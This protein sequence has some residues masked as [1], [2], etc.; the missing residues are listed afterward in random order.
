VPEAITWI[1]I[2]FIKSV[3]HFDPCII[4]P[5]QTLH[6]FPEWWIVPPYRIY[7]TWSTEKKLS[8]IWNY[9]LPGNNRDCQFLKKCL[10]HKM[11]KEIL[12]YQPCVQGLPQTHTHMHRSTE[13]NTHKHTPAHT[14]MHRS[15]QTNSHTHTHT[16]THTHIH[17]H[18]LLLECQTFWS[19]WICGPSCN[20]S[21][22]QQ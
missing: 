4:I 20:K 6:T 14:H 12:Y 17:T 11:T 2:L 10:S 16:H 13:K 9:W 19:Q 22:F 15:I 3:M 1:E 21:T 5:G 7:C 8:S 18:S